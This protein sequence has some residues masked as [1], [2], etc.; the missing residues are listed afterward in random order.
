MLVGII[1][2]NNLR[3]SPYI[4]FYTQILDELQLEYELIYPDRGGISDTFSKRIHRIEWRKDV[5]TLL[6]YL[7]YAKRVISLVKEREYDCLVVL[8]GNNA[9]FLSL[10]LKKYFR[11]KYIVDIRDYTH[12]NIFPYYWLEAKAIRNSALCVISSKRFELFLPRWKYCVCHNISS[13][14]DNEQRKFTQSADP[15]V[16]GYIGKGSYIQECKE[17]CA[18]VQRDNRFVMHIHGLQTVPKEIMEFAECSNISIYGLFDPSQKKEIINSVDI[19]FNVYG[20]GTPL[21]DYALSNKLYDSLQYFKPILTSP[22][23][24]MA[25]IAGPLSFE[26]DFSNKRLLDDLYNWYRNLNESSIEEYAKGKLMEVKR[27]NNKTRNMIKEVFL[28]QVKE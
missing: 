28:S 4:F 23:T 12:E 22:G 24:Y 18:L 17:L 7:L 8:T 2:A 10:W 9:T 6:S 14:D 5:P 21:L 15:I 27:E 1:A 13:E 26:V 19:L 16:I 20:N 11:G 25:E 3:F